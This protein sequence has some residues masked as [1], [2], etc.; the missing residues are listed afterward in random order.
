LPAKVL[1]GVKWGKRPQ[2]NWV[3]AGR[4]DPEEKGWTN[5]C[6][7]RRKKRENGTKATIDRVKW[8]GDLFGK[9]KSRLNHGRTFRRSKE[10]RTGPL[11]GLKKK[12][13]RKPFNCAQKKGGKRDR[14]TWK[15]GLEVSN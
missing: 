5:C 10:P 12:G 2:K 8:E 4:V 3:A 7:M 6:V 9:R 13:K 11:K 14:E 1:P 15:G